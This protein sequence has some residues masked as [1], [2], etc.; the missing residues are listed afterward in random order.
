MGTTT[1]TE[2]RLP[3]PTALTTTT[4]TTTSEAPLPPQPIT[5]T[6][7]TTTTTEPPLPPR[8]CP[9]SPSSSYCR[10]S[11]PLVAP[12]SEPQS[13]GNSASVEQGGERARVRKRYEKV[14][15]PREVCDNCGFKHSA[16]H[17]S[18]KEC[19]NFRANMAKRRKRALTPVVH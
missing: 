8:I 18:Q 11:A 14:H 10:V 12:P 17:P 13:P 16:M 3:P 15:Q 2:P 9:P 19:R 7:L 5:T 1:T 4:T 6:A